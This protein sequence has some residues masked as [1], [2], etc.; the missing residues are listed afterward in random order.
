[1]RRDPAFIMLSFVDREAAVF[2]KRDFQRGES[3]QFL[4]GVCVPLTK[5]EEL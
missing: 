2:A 3:I 1:M 5:E 4:S